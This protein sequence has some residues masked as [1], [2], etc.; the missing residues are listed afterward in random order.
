[1]TSHVQNGKR[2]VNKNKQR[3]PESLRGARETGSRAALE[4]KKQVPKLVIA[5]AAGTAILGVA[6]AVAASRRSARPRWLAPRESSFLTSP[7]AR[8]AG[9]WLLRAVAQRVVAA[10]A[11]KLVDSHAPA[12][13]SSSAA[14]PSTAAS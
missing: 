7:I 1:M 9:L 13:A 3:F 4:A 8:A 6:V 2:D 10:A 5:A 14:R 12:S 11:V